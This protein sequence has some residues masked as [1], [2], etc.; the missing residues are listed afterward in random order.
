MAR[1]HR[2][3]RGFA[4]RARRGDDAVQPSVPRLLPV[5]GPGQRAVRKTLIFC[6]A[7]NEVEQVAA[8]LRQHLPY[9]AAILVHYSNLD[10]I[11]RREI[12]TRFSEA[13]VAICVSSSTLELGVDIGN[14]NDVVLLGPP[15]SLSSFLQRIGRGARRSQSTPVLCIYRTPLEEV[16]F[17][18]LLDV[19][20]QEVDSDNLE[21]PDYHFRPSVLVQQIF[22]FLSNCSRLQNF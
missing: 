2:R 14:I 13:T 15:P 12:E 5:G 6:N 11:M 18:A 4:S 10:P 7:R 9:E 19:A 17:H 3:N 8:Y 21:P 16:R 1:N 22:S 20:E